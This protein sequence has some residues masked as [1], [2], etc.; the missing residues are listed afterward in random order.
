MEEKG[1]KRFPGAT[2]QKSAAKRATSAASK[3]HE[4]DRFNVKLVQ[5]L[6]CKKIQ[7]V[8]KRCTGCGTQFGDYFC[9]SCTLYDSS[10]SSKGIFHCDGCGVCRTGGAENFFHCDECNA[11]IS[12]KVKDEHRHIEDATKRDCPICLQEM[13]SST[14]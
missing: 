2:N 9:K 6:D 7:G 4:F 8:S 14:E 5:C 10:S 12:I 3:F 1:Q 11:C 13:F